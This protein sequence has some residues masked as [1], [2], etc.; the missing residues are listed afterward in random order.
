MT[1]HYLIQQV[2]YSRNLVFRRNFPIHKLFERSCE[3]GLLR[4]TPDKI[5]QI[6]GF[7][8][9][10]T[11]RGKLQTVLE[12][13]EHGH[14]VF[15]TCGKSAVLRMYEKFATFLR[16]EVLSN[17]LKDFGLKKSLG[18]LDAVRQKLAA[19]TD[20]FA[21]FEAEALNVHVDFP[22]FQRLALPITSGRSRVA[23]IKIQDTRM[24]RLMEVLLQSGTRVAGWRTAQTHEA[25]LSAERKQCE[26]YAPIFLVFSYR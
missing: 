18:N 23:G 20:G 14:H 16:L 1:R 13:I 17:Q 9:H 15:C 6:S 26:L 12:K 21:A 24:I 11:L 3:I 7:R 25:I 2:E 5:T 22:L 19:V 8:I 10:K 4:L